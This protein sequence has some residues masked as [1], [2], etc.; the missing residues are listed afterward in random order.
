MRPA[1]LAHKDRQSGDERAIGMLVKD[2]PAAPQLVI[3]RPP[4][5]KPHQKNLCRNTKLFAGK[6]IKQTADGLDQRFLRSQPVSS[7]LDHST[8]S[9]NIDLFVISY[10]LRLD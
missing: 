9:A 5:T 6:P 10:H 3:Q 1:Q 8:M 4:T 2:A 7:G